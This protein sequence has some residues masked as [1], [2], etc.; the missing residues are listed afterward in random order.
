[1]LSDIQVHLTSILKVPVLIRI[2]QEN[3]LTTTLFEARVSSHHFPFCTTFT[4]APLR[5]TFVLYAAIIIWSIKRYVNSN[6]HT[7][8][9]CPEDD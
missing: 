3:N 9:V 5:L 4:R 7:K 1:M 8:T 2:K 6:N